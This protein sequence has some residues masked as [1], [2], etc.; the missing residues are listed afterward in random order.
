MRFILLCL[1]ATTLSCATIKAPREFPSMLN[2]D[3]INQI[4][5][6]YE[7]KAIQSNITFFERICSPDL[8]E[9]MNPDGPSKFELRIPNKNRIEISFYDDEKIT[10]KKVL[11]F[12]SLD[13][14]LVIKGKHNYRY[15][16]VPLLFYR[17]E[18][19]ALWISQKKQDELFLAFNGSSSGGI[20][21]LIF[22]TPIEGE[23]RF[24]KVSE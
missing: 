13:G 1:L 19:Q 2:A 8:V 14:G 22:G 15:Q 21:I 6:I 5:G 23:A 12:S 11:K 16:G 4:E 3:T 7:N 17:S 18:S 10:Y 24:R 20:F 9:G